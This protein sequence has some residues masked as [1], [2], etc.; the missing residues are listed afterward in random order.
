MRRL[1]LALWQGKG[2]CTDLVIKMIVQLIQGGFLGVVS[3]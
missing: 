3:P 2:V 1:W